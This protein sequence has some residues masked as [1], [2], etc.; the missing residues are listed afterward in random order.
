L[1]EAETLGTVI[2]KANRAI[3]L[4]RLHAEIIVA[5]NGSTDGSQEQKD[6]KYCD[7]ALSHNFF[8]LLFVIAPANGEETGSPGYV[9]STF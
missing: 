1:N 3:A 4:H 7:K 2:R 8:L 5:D 9:S 6:N